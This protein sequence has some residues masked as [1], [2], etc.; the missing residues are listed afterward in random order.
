[1]TAN[2]VA[3]LLGQLTCRGIELAAEGDRLRYR[4]SSKITPTL[5][6]RLRRHKVDLVAA[7]HA[8][9]DRNDQPAAAYTQAERE[10]L[11]SASPRLRESVDLIKFKVADTGGATV[12]DVHQKSVAYRRQAAGCPR[13]QT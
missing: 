7:L 1:M 3:V 4:P 6:D 5:L 11:A 13:R 2:P 12:L 9:E 10:L 8:V